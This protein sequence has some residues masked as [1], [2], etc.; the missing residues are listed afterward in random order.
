[1]DLGYVLDGAS[2][3]GVLRIRRGRGRGYLFGHL[4]TSTPWLSVEP[5]RFTGDAVAAVVV[6]DTSSLLIG[7]EPY[8]AEVLVDSLASATP[9][10]V[11]VQLRVVPM[12]SGF[13][14]YVLRPL[15]GALVAGV[16]G[17]L[18]GWLTL[19]AGSTTGLLPGGGLLPATVLPVA[20]IAVLWGLL[21]A[22]RGAF[23]PPAWPIYYAT[24]RWLRRML[25]WGAALVLV[26]GL[27]AWSWRLGSTGTSGAPAFPYPLAALSGLIAAV[28][29]ATIGEI[30]AAR[31]LR[32]GSARTRR[33]RAFGSA[34]RLATGLI[35]LLILLAV[36]RFVAPMLE[37]AD[38][39]AQFGAL[40]DSVGAG[41]GRINA[42]AD[43]LTNRFY[44]RY[45]DRRAPEPAGEGESSTLEPGLR[46]SEIKLP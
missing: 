10:A 44:L 14:R 13:S 6:A 39:R 31:A 45:F 37:R 7:P 15:T 29:P 4:T 9:I 5:K 12:P 43:D 22:V 20:L 30:Q 28:L 8:R 1:V 2:A 32:H 16:V 18:L 11:P 3:S 36:P 27:A 17:S 19:R 40:R 41:W 23:Q 21:G 35:F 33:Q 25:K 24:Y 46:S 34:L 42:D 26:G 38:V